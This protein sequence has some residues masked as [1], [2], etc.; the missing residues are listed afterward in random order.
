M[1]P[2]LAD[3]VVKLDC[4]YG[5]VVPVEIKHLFPI[6]FHFSRRVLHLLIFISFLAVVSR[7][8][9]I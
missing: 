8:L 6:Y 2:L 7:V 9:S 1:D 3:A 5:N 4:G